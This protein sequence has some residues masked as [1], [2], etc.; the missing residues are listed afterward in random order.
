MGKG[1]LREV[2]EGKKQT[3]KDLNLNDKE[4]SDT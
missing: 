2:T 4:R 3:G 1:K